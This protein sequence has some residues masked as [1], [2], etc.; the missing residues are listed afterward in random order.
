MGESTRPHHPDG[1]CVHIRD[2]E[3]LDKPVAVGMDCLGAGTTADIRTD[4]ARV[5]KTERGI[6][7]L[8]R[9]PPVWWFLWASVAPCVH[10]RGV[11]LPAL[12]ESCPGIPTAADRVHTHR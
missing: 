2:I 11:S 10:K 1:V 3:V 7:F 9:I 6:R 4:V 12:L 8:A 5:Q